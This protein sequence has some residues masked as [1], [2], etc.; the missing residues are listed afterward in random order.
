MNEAEKALCVHITGV[1]GLIGNLVY[2]HLSDQGD[3]YDTYGSSRRAAGSNRADKVAIG[4]IPTDRFAVADLGDAEAVLEAF[5]GMDAVLHIA[6]VP[7]PEAPFPD[8]LHSNIIGT[9]NVLEACRRAGVRRLVYASSIMVN[10]G[11]FQYEEPYRSIREGRTHTIPQPIPL[12]THTQPTRPTEPYSASKV[13]GEAICRTYADAHGISTV[14]LRIG[15]VTREDYSPLPSLNSVWC[16]QRDIVHFIEHAL[17]ATDKPG[18]D[19][20]YA[21]SDNRHRWVDLDHARERL[22]YTPQDSAESTGQLG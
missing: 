1:Y 22:G 9:Y 17:A 18:F 16:S 14:C 10:W 13:W 20:F 5:R 6:A 11:T 3:R 7:D 4:K 8:I 2:R 19:T 12:I 15:H 21:V